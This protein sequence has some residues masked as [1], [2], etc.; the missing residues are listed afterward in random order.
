MNRVHRKGVDISTAFSTAMKRLRYSASRTE[1][2][3]SGPGDTGHVSSHGRRNTHPPSRIP[4]FSRIWIEKTLLSIAQLGFRLAEP[5]VSRLRYY[6]TEGLRQEILQGLQTGNDALAARLDRIEGL[7]QEILQELQT[8]NDALV[9]IEQYTS[10]TARRIAINCDNGEVLVSTGVGFVICAADDPALLAC[11]IDTGELELGTR[12]LIQKLLKPG[13]VYVDV[14]ANIGM[15]TLA[16]ARAMQGRGKII[17]F[18]PFEPT[19]RML[20]KSLWMNGF[21]GIAEIHQV[22]VSNVTGRQNLYLGAT[23]GH[24]SLFRLEDMPRGFSQE[25]VEVPLVRLDEIIPSDQMVDL[26]KI[27]AEGAELEVIEGGESLITSNPDIALIVEFGPSHLR[28]RGQTPK[29]WIEAFTKLGL[30]YRAI[31]AY[32]GVLEVW[33]IERLERVES[34]NL[35]F[36]RDNSKAW[37]RLAA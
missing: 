36:S 29:Q 16:A 10:A 23:S 3:V 30:N 19:T 12:I 17:A 32:S 24:H 34:V 33:P 1:G 21:S 14:G 2:P 26:L 7:S 37:S 5:I 6:F 27:D 11:L 13:D 25:P 22:A 15:H 9:R 35:F 31:N 28:R 18:E 8:G 4:F 20:A